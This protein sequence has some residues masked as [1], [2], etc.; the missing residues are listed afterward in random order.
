MLQGIKLGSRLGV[1]L[2]PIPHIG[3][4]E[5]YAQNLSSRIAEARACIFDNLFRGSLTIDDQDYSIH[6]SRQT[7]G[8]GDCH[9]RG[10][11]N[12]DVVIVLPEGGKNFV[13]SS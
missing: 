10:G 8:I 7:H 11:V 12:E 1:H 9:D 5:H 4:V 13:H 3:T 2:V 6:H